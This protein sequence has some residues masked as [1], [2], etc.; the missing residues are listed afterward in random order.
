VA[1]IGTGSGA[2]AISLALALPQ[3]K[4]FATDISASALQVA[5]IN[6]R[7]YRVDGHV[8]L[9]QGDLLEPLPEPVDI[10]TAN[11]PYIKNCELKTLNLEITNF[12][13]LI[14]LVGGDDGLEKIRRL[15]DQ[16]P[17]KIHPEGCL[18]LEIGQGQGEIVK[19]SIY[20]RFPEAMINLI[21]DLGGVERVVKV[22][23]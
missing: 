7:R 4:I 12:E 19:P 11:L 23:I 8:I 15:L 6:C 18:F 1:D 20:N 21:P 2:I 9:L 10:I 22:S 5:E 3:A 13:P 17:G 16:I 14:A